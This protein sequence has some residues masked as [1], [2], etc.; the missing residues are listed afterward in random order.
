MVVAETKTQTLEEAKA[1]LRKNFLTGV[2]CPCCRQFVKLY[3][4]KLHSSMAVTLIRIFKYYQEG[5]AD[6]S[7]TEIHVKE[8]LRRNK[9]KNAHDWML[10]RYWKLIEPIKQEK[11]TTNRNGYWRITEL[12]RSFVLGSVKV[13]ASVFIYNSRLYGSDEKLTD[14]KQALGN[15][16]DYNELMLRTTIE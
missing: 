7:L 5:S 9:F 12:G 10:L 14:I 1:F 6:G 15:A 16:F 13:P 2:D 11:E 4:R 3:K 8:Y